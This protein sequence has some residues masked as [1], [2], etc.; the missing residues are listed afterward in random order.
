M[1]QNTCVITEDNNKLLASQDAVIDNT[2]PKISKVFV[3]IFQ[4]T[5]FVL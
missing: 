4:P 2:G 5:E 3:R 1:T